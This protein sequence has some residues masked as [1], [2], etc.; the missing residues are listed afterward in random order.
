MKTEN[1]EI[2]EYE[3]EKLWKLWNPNRKSMKPW[4]WKRGCLKICERVW[5]VWIW[6]RHISMIPKTEYETEQYNYGSWVFNL[7]LIQISHMNPWNTR[8]YCQGDS[9]FFGSAFFKRF[10]LRA[11]LQKIIFPFTSSSIF[12]SRISTLVLHVNINII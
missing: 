5:N 1:H 12:K 6:D 9:L 4:I 8:L 7:W 3:I 2:H 11:F 10:V